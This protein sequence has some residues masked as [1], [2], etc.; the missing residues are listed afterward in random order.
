ME[1]VDKQRLLDYRYLRMASIWSENS[2][3]VRRKVGALIVKDKMIISDG[4]NGTPSGFPN[5]CESAEGV[6]FP[7]VLHAEANAITKVARSN[8]SSEGSTLYVTASPC[9]ECSKLIIQAGIKRVVF[10]E[11]YRITDGLDLLRQAGV[12]TVHLPLD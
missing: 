1:K 3:C 10:S 6:T 5:I 12:E 9:M 4:F 8:N 11:L 7:Y 2:Y